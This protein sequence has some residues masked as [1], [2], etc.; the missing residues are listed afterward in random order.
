MSVNYLTNLPPNFLVNILSV[1]VSSYKHTPE[2]YLMLLSRNARRGIG[3]IPC[4]CGKQAA[5]TIVLRVHRKCPNGMHC[6]PVGRHFN[7]L[8][9]VRIS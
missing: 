6:L 3:S 7:A 1:K 5:A 2:R 9:M 8:R 4:K